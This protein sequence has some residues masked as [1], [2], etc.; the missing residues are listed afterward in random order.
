MTEGR[1]EGRGIE[2]ERERESY[3]EEDVCVVGRCVGSLSKESVR[4]EEHIN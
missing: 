1:R 3:L 4:L 2:I